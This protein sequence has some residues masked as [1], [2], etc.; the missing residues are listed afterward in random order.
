VDGVCFRL[1]L[2]SV[3]TPMP[4]YTGAQQRE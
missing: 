3:R 2:A 1:L 4:A